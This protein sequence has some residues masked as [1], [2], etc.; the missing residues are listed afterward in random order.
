MKSSLS[1]S[2]KHDVTI[3]LCFFPI[4]QGKHARF[5]RFSGQVVTI[6]K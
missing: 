2:D 3:T 1:E 5:S 4:Y 6:E